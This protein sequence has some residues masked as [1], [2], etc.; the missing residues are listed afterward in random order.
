MQQQAGPKH[1]VTAMPKKERD[2]AVA[3]IRGWDNPL[4]NV[5]EFSIYWIYEGF[6]GDYTQGPES[7]WPCKDVGLAVSDL[8]LSNWNKSQNIRNHGDAV[9]RS[10]TFLKTEMFFLVWS[11]NCL[12]P[13]GTIESDEID[14]IRTYLSEKERRSTLPTA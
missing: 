5:G 2:F 9:S 1:I 11:R 3:V 7:E 4:Q 13:L 8:M 14:K 6:T 12:R 10:C